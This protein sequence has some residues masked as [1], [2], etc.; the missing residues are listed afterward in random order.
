VTIGPYGWQG[1]DT[2]TIDMDD[3]REEPGEPDWV[4]AMLDTEEDLGHPSADGPTVFDQFVR[5]IHT[6]MRGDE[7]GVLEH[8][9]ILRAGLIALRPPSGSGEL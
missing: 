7:A 6:A 1:L 5:N 9:R 4:R 3:Y 8:T 2:P